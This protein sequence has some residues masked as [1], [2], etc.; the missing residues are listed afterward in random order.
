MG[1]HRVPS[2][3]KRARK[4]ARQLLALFIIVCLN[5]RWRRFIL[6][7][8]EWLHHWPAGAAT[9]KLAVAARTTTTTTTTAATST[10]RT[11]KGG[12]I[13]P[14]FENQNNTL[15]EAAAAICASLRRLALDCALFAL[16]A[17]RRPSA[18]AR[19]LMARNNRK[20]FPLLSAPLA[21]CATAA[22][23]S[24]VSAKQAPEEREKEQEEE[25]ERLREGTKCSRLWHR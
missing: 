21:R 7:A 11:A 18:C 17:G 13:S 20:S 4:S 5:G 19:V 25:K 23:V 12:Q 16:S 15:M 1:L 8:T 22:V 3:G 14:Q 2:R 24:A 10:K 6:V 9:P